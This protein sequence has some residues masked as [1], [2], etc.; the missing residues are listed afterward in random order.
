MAFSCCADG[1]ER[2]HDALLSVLEE[3][4]I[5]LF[6][7]FFSGGGRKNGLPEGWP[8]GSATARPVP[9]AVTGSRS[10]GKP[11]QSGR[12]AG[13]L[14]SARK[15]RLCIS[16]VPDGETFHP[17]PRSS[18]SLTRSRAPSLPMKKQV[19]GST[20]AATPPRRGQPGS[21]RPARSAPSLR[22]PDTCLTF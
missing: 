11:L 4:G 6:S 19:R 18:T 20:G 5:F 7:T 21:P 17:S 13:P 16:F 15:Q 12:C 14:A 3:V 9:C 2:A 10:A 8:A 22:Q 1:R